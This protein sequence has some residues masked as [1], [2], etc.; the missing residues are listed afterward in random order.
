[1][2]RIATSKLVGRIQTNAH[3]TNRCVVGCILA[4][5]ILLAVPNLAKAQSLT[6]LGTLG[7]NSSEARDVTVTL[8]G[9]I[10]VVGRS[11]DAA[12]NSRAF[13]WTPQTGM[14]DLGSAIDTLGVSA[15]GNVVVGGNPP[16]RWTPS[17]GIQNLTSV[18]GW[19]TDVSADGN[20]VVGTGHFYWTPQSGEQRLLNATGW[21]WGVSADGRVVGGWY[22][23]PGS[24]NARAYRWTADSFRDYPA[25]PG[26]QQSVGVGISPDGNY[27]LGYLI[28]AS[29]HTPARFTA[30]GQIETFQGVS[31]DSYIRASSRDNSILVGQVNNRAARWING[32]YE[33]L[34]VTYADL[35]PADSLLR[36]AYGISADGRYIV[37][38]GFNSRTGRT[39]GYLL[40]TQGRPPCQGDV[41]NDGRVD[42]S[43]L[44][45][46]LFNFG[47]SR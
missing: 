19:A 47:C 36:A 23:P 26:Y 22:Y 21:A 8:D 24:Y 37:G 17:T 45:I 15:D 28:S 11:L 1:M 3:G 25:P 16:W 7:G 5:T 32:Q 40:D 4:F 2:M 33:D 31:G 12:G 9:Q 13:R 41:N 46:V 35:L 10:V 43:D 27:V 14:Q 18:Y 44:L 42:D 39:E 34:N 30:Q 6:W 29:G 20:V 38:W